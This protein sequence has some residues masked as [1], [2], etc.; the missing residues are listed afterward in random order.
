ML[1]GHKG[2]HARMVVS[3]HNE[4]VVEGCDLVLQLLEGLQNCTFAVFHT[5]RTIP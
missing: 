1:D 2:H 4:F 5:L 3:N